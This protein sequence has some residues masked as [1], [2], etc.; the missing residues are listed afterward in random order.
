MN[1]VIGVPRVLGI[2]YKNRV[3]EPSF[4]ENDNEDDKNAST[5]S[6]VNDMSGNGIMEKILVFTHSQVIEVIQ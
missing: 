3:K 6:L 2:V 1:G 5:L 4:H